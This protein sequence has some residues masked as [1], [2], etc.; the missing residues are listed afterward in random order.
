MLS[1]DPEAAKNVVLGE[2][3]LIS[4][5]TI[6]LDESL[7]DELI[8]HISTLASVYHKPPEAFVS[9]LR[10]VKKEKKQKPSES[11]DSPRTSHQP[12]SNL[13]D[14]DNLGSSPSSSTSSTPQ[15]QSKASNLLDDFFSQPVQPVFQ[16]F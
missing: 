13:L 2:K 8:S 3:P 11:V 6:R 16:L 9:K 14:L 15:T 10:E 1:T 5:S 7:L 12:Q 4:D